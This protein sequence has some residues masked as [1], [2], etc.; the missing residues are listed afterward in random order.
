MEPR[1]ADMVKSELVSKRSKRVPRLLTGMFAIAFAMAGSLFFG[2][3]PANAEEGQACDWVFF[4]PALCESWTG[5]WPTGYVRAGPNTHMWYATKLQTSASCTADSCFYDVAGSLET[6]YHT[7][8]PY[9][10]VGKYNWY[11]A[12]E[13][14][15]PGG[16]W[17]CAGSKG[18]A[19]LG[20]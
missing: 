14:S 6:G 3:S 19:Y 5:G 9:V 12:C 11:R 13:Q 16:R 17:N 15:I 7:Y 4:T 18:I 10:K 20:D 1:M 8:G 2:S